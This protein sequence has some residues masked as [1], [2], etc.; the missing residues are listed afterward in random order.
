MKLSTRKSAI[1]TFIFI[2]MC[3]VSC[4]LYLIQRQW[5]TAMWPL[6]TAVWTFNVWWSDKQYRQLKTTTD[7]LLELTQKFKA[8]G[9][10][11]YTLLCELGPEVPPGIAN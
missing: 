10:A 8:R 5:L 1:F 3:L 4:I 2:V 7:E 11:L 6:C 9:D